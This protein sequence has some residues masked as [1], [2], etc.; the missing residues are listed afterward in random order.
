MAWAALGLLALCPFGQGIIIV[1]AKAVAGAVTARYRAEAA[2]ERLVAH[3]HKIRAAQAGTVGAKQGRR[4]IG[5][6][7]AYANTRRRGGHRRPEAA[8][9]EAKAAI[10]RRDALRPRR[11]LSRAAPLA[12]PLAILINAG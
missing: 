11:E 4:C 8:A 9:G 7:H 3:I 12:G 6:I 2:Y 5:K 10:V 1:V